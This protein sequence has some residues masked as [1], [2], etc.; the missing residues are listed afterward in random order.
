MNGFNISNYDADITEILRLVPPYDNGEACHI[1]D[2]QIA[3]LLAKDHPE[4]LK[5]FE[6]KVGGKGIGEHRSLAQI[7]GKYLS[8]NLDGFGI[9]RAFFSTK[10]L[11]DFR[12]SGDGEI[13]EASS[14]EFAIFRLK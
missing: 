13:Q 9:E 7:I 4:I 3:A 14:G 8:A 10:G 12:F 2:Y 5:E 6:L 11:E 1:S